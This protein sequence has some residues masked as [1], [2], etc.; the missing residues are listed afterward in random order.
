MAQAVS[1][2]HLTAEARIRAPISPYGICGGQSGTGTGFTLSMSF[3]RRSP[4]SYIN[5]GW[6][7]GPLVAAVQRHG[8]TPTW[9]RTMNLYSTS[10]ITL[11]YFISIHLLWTLHSDRY[12]YPNHAYLSRYLSI[13]LEFRLIYKDTAIRERLLFLRCYSRPTLGNMK[14]KIFY[15]FISNLQT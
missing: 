11:C 12:K 15:I 8:F 3:H 1:R 14:F 7:I 10:Y 9:T 6:T 4:Y 2:R 5:W 13:F